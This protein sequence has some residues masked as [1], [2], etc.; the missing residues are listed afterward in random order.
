MSDNMLA[1]R[2][3]PSLLD[4]LTDDA[5]NDKVEARSNRAIDLSRLRDIIKRDLAWLLNTNS[6]EGLLDPK[7]YPNVVK[8]V[9]NYGVREVAGEY[10]TSVRAE[11]IRKSIQKAISIHEPRIISGST[12]VELRSEDKHGEMQIAFDIHADMWA[13]PVPLEL[14]LRSKVDVTTGEVTL[15]RVG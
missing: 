9:L 6:I 15:D 4:R 10:S 1:E 11:L 3:Q 12:A 7:L 14:Y 5:P 8:S 2:L 13:Q